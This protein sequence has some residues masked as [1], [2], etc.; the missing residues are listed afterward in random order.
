[1]TYYILYIAIYKKI[2]QKSRVKHN[3][4]QKMI[5]HTLKQINYKNIYKVLKYIKN[6][7]R[8]D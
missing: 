1:M 4:V 3:I 6:L 5:K 7:H 2:I 8:F